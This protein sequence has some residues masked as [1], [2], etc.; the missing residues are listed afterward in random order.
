VTANHYVTAYFVGCDLSTC[1]TITFQPITATE[2]ALTSLALSARAS[3]GLPVS[4]T[5]TTPKVC[6]VSGNTA[7]LLFPGNCTIKASQAGDDSWES[8]LPVHRTFTVGLATQTVTFPPIP[9]QKQ[10]ASFNLHATAS[11]GMNVAYYARSSPVTSLAIGPAPVCEIFGTTAVML[12][13]G[14]CTI[15]AYQAGDDLYAPA[16]AAQSFIVKAP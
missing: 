7:S 1:Q 5:S 16:S 2:N 14:T 10:G 4:F 9:N 13:P 8:A 15:S 11:S 12:S 6:T 3:S